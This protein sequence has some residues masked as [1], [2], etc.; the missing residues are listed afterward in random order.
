MEKIDIRLDKDE[1]VIATILLLF[2]TYYPDYP[3]LK[4]FTNISF[5]ERRDFITLVENGRW[6][7]TEIESSSVEQVQFF[8]K[9]IQEVPEFTGDVFVK[10]NITRFSIYPSE[11]L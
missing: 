11:G 3:P 10:N 7:F 4:S 8:Q 5:P 9:K 6:I 2:V 1:I